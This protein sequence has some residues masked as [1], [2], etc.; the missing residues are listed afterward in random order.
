MKIQGPNPLI[1]A[2]KNQHQKHITNKTEHQKDRLNISTEAK[3]LQL[4][5]QYD[6]ERSKYVDEIKQLVQSGEYK[7]DHDKTAQKMIDFWTKRI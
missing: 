4:D 2:Y 1:N 5:K 3:K 6:V 7:V